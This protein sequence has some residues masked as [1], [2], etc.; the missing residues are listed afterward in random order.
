MIN[1]EIEFEELGIEEKKLLL[2]AFGFKVNEDGTVYDE[3]LGTPIFS[4]RHKGLIN[5][6]EVALMPGSLNL[7][8]SDPV[9]LSE[10][11]REKIEC[12]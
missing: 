11:L 5:I 4:K 8:D 1:K 12:D 7:I 10:F 3:E 2:G 9:S 6:N